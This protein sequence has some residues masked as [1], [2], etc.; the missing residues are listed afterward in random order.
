MF[1]FVNVLH[2]GKE[3]INN[4]WRERFYTK[5][6][7]KSSF[8]VIIISVCLPLAEIQARYLF[9]MLSINC[10]VL[11]SEQRSQMSSRFTL[12]DNLI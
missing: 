4:T 2:L 7:E 1:Y 12:L 3:Y 10:Q 11:Q 9:F 6:N 8:S 5:I